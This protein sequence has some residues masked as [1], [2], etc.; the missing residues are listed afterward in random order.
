MRM[1]H[2]MLATGFPMLVWMSGCATA[3]VDLSHY[4]RP[5][6]SSRM[7]PYE[8]FIG[9][10][11]WEA[12]MKNADGD[13]RPWTGTAEWKWGLDGRVLM[14]EMSAKGKNAEFEAHGVWSWHPTQRKYVWWMF[15]NWGYPQS[16]TARY[17]AEDQCWTMSYRS[18]GLDG[19]P[20]YGR[21]TMKVIDSDTL[22]WTSKEWADPLRLITKMEMEG[23]YKRR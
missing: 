9:S 4:G 22:H 3:K 19:S 10:W 14:G 17:S 1:R 16:G 20:S 11:N 6:R 13:D 12:E 21:Y 15:N 7:E 2:V 5:D 23:T 18:V 8:V